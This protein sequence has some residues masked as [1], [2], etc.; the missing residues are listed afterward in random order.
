MMTWMTILR[1]QRAIV[2][3][4]GRFLRILQP[5]QHWVWTWPG[6]VDVERVDL[7]A[8]MQPLT[9][10][11]FPD[12]LPGT[13]ILTVGP[14]QRVIR[15]VQ[16]RVVQVLLPGRY[17]L[18]NAIPHESFEVVELMDEPAHLADNDILYPAHSDWTT[19]S[20]TSDS[21]LVLIRNGEAQRALAPGRYRFWAGG[22]WGATAIDTRETTVEMATQD[23]LTADQVTVRVKPE[24]TSQ[25]VDPTAFV[26]TGAGTTRL[27][28][29]VQLALREVIST[30]TLEG[31]VDQREVM[32]ETL[33]KRAQ[34]LLPDTGVALT[35]AWVKD[36]ILP[37]EVKDLLN[38]VT[39]AR[40]QAEA[41][42]IKRR[43][44]VASTRQLANTAKL[45]DKNPVLLRLK[46]LEALG[47]L[48]GKIDKLVVVGSPDLMNSPLLRDVSQ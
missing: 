38:R 12:E 18:W 45:L 2:L 36:I 23:L 28:A 6:L 43:E 41:Q 25:V 42:S 24:F 31:L 29:A 21:A 34:A 48:V 1:N 20:S 39:L 8:A 19:R 35:A 5:G 13:D 14:A 16:G 44:E 27:Y 3:R 10:S 11:A 26:R 33:T 30:V 40:K 47:E 4:N 46:E 9:R 22:P 17:R 15:R 37:G 7:A 32:S